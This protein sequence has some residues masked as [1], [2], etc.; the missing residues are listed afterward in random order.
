MFD[1]INKV[2]T[3]VFSNKEED[4]EGFAG[5]IIIRPSGTSALLA[6]LLTVFLYLAIV[7]AIGMYL[8]NNVLTKLVPGVKPAKSI[9]QILGLV[10]LTQLL[11]N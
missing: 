11:F 1:S 5:H 2:L 4:K 10:L 9:W 8:W 3:N 7:S 6:F